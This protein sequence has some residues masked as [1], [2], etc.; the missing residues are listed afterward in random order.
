MSLPGNLG[1]HITRLDQ[2]GIVV[3]DVDAAADQFGSLLGIGPFRIMDWPIDGVDPEGIYLDQPAKW[4]MRE[5]F[6]KLGPI[7]IELIQPLE[8]RSIY[9]DFLQAHGP[10]LHH[11]R[12]S[13]EPFDAA[14]VAL[15]A[16]GLRV[17]SSGTGVH[18]GSRWAYIDTRQLLGGVLVELRQ[19][20]DETHGEVPFAVDLA[21]PTG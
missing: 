4:R 10:G 8:G 5:G 13:V 21:K 17:L 11:I 15:K 1:L 9:S 18:V 3:Q 2:I 20:L 14:V 6:C 19:Q 12:F 16:A 7:Q